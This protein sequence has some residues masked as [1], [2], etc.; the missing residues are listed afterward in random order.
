MAVASKGV[1][2]ESGTNELEIVEF[3]IGKQR[4]G[5]NVA[6]VQ[7]IVKS[8]PSTDVPKAHPCVKGLILYRNQTITLIDIAK[9]L[10]GS[11]KSEFFILTHFNQITLA[12]AVCQIIG[13]KRFSWEDI[14]KPPSIIDQGDQTVLTGVIESGNNLTAIL[15]FE[16][17]VNEISP[18]TGIQESSVLELGERPTTDKPIIVVEDSP[19]LKKIIIQCLTTAKFTNILTFDNGK[20]AWDYLNLFESQDQASREVACV[21]SDIEM[22]EMDGHKLTRLIREKKATSQVPII[23]FSSLISEPMRLKG[24][25]LGANAQISKPEIAKLVSLLDRFLGE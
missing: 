11:G 22:P 24:E 17:I 20:Q 9:Y 12:F 23:L 10:N 5:I 21:I 15:D 7:E 4:Y 1:L 16:K 8:I 2:L 14:K 19:M 18:K 25:K 3:L 13:I 6:K